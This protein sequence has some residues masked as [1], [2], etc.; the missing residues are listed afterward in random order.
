M[1]TNAPMPIR[2]MRHAAAPSVVPEQLLEVAG[3][4]LRGR[5]RRGMDAKHLRI[6]DYTLKVLICAGDAAPYRARHGITGWIQGFIRI[7]RCG[8]WP[9]AEQRRRRRLG[10]GS[11]RE[12]A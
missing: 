5:G 1:G 7:R 9:R 8:P 11:G 2:A 10:G 3:G 4:T 6:A 12:G